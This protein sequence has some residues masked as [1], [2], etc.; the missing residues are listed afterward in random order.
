VSGPLDGVRVV[1]LGGIG[2]TTFASMMLADLGADVLRIDRPETVESTTRA[3]DFALTRGRR[4]VA[5]NLKTTE[6]AALALRLLAKADIAIEGWR[7]GVAE[8]IGVGPTEALGTNSKLVYVRATGWGQDGPYSQ[9]P[10]HDINY[11]AVTG[12]LHAIGRRDQPPVPPLNIV[13][14]YGAG[15]MLA[16]VGALAALV[17]AK[18]S[19]RGQ[20]VDAAM[21]DGIALL[22]TLFHGM[23]STGFW[24]D[25][26]E[27]NTV[28]GGAP[29]YN[30]YLTADGKYVC[31]GAGEPHFFASILKML[32]IDGEFDNPMD[33]SK[34]PEMRSRF[35]ELFRTATREE[36]AV[37]L[38]DRELCLTPVLTWHEAPLDEHLRQRGTF[39]QLDGVIQPAPAPRFS[40]TL[41]AVHRPPPW[42]GQHTFEA[43]VD[44]GIGAPEIRAYLHDQ[45]VL[46]RTSDQGKLAAEISQEEESMDVAQTTLYN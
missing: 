11:L 46:E 13:G 4:S 25:E 26:R 7:P 28:D 9:A 38:G 1:E 12:A 31:I 41:T 14:D 36:W 44:W 29:W 42:P 23:L 10:G 24:T 33:R 15:G 40:R 34:W 22:T 45:T 37:R 30:S 5:I 16:V 19:G 2:P 20:I 39:V 21:V 32:G 8:R 43:L 17:E 6:G 18:S 35:A 3:P 27:N